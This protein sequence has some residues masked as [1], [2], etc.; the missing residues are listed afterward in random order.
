MVA[1]AL[2]FIGFLQ[3][4]LSAIDAAYSTLSLLALNYTP[5]GGEISVVLQ[6]ARFMVPAAAAFA[7][8]SA[9][10]SVLSDQV[11]LVRAQR[12]RDHVIV[13]GLGR[14]GT[15]LVR[16]IRTSDR[17]LDVVAIEANASSPNVKVCR[18]LGAS[19]VI[20][21]AA[22]RET[23]EAARVDRARTLITVLPEDADNAA[24]ASVAREFC[25]DRSRPLQAFAHVGD[26]DLVE[27]LT[28]A[29]VGSADEGFVLEW[30]SVHERAAR[31]LLSENLD[32]PA[33]AG[34]DRPR[35]GIVGSDD[36]ARSIVINAARQWRAIAGTNAERLAIT[37]AWPG[38][39]R[40]TDELLDRHP[41]IGRAVELIA[42]ERDVRAGAALA[43]AE[44]AFA[45]VDTVFVCAPTDIESLDHAFAVARIIGA[46]RTVVVRLLI[47]EGGFVD[48]LEFGPAPGSL[49]LFSIVDRAC[50]YQMVTAGLYEQI[51]QALHAVYLRQDV[52][53]AA[54]LPW[55]ELDA[56][57]REASRAQALDLTNKLEEIG[58]DV[59]PLVDWDAPL[60]EF[61]AAET[62]SLAAREHARWSAAKKLQGYVWGERTDDAVVPPTNRFVDVPWEALVRESPDAAEW[63][64]EFARSIPAVVAAAGYEVYRVRRSP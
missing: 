42:Y 13:C 51:A 7:T 18:D 14:R 34:S 11:D 16:S 9:I 54:S 3:A 60:V 29:A 58:C 47:E 4:G 48:V 26:I 31:L 50:S 25:G 6:I 52:D 63:N 35:I 21:N 49:Q 46:E 41:S 61:S 5:P 28:S 10:L 27:E 56:R 15:R 44:A 23:M 64:R 39:A 55:T 30:F 57:F 24:V 62:E 8:L 38:A 17:P 12:R 32:L 33:A 19:V 37:V 20:G 53:S 22:E 43:E 45:H 1:L 40:W 36:L 2:G 59:R